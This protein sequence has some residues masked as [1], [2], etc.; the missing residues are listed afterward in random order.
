MND[1]QYFQATSLSYQLKAA[2]K[3]LA[4]FRS[5]EAY[6]LFP[7]PVKSNYFLLLSQIKFI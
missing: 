1:R 3:K 4:L 6:T 7:H 5:G 2:Q